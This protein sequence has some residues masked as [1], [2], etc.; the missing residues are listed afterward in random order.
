MTAN[1][2]PCPAYRDSG[3]EWLGEESRGIGRWRRCVI[4]RRSSVLEAHPV[5][6]QPSTYREAFR[7]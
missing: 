5:V 3:V 1:L 6:E 4:S 2:T 7:F